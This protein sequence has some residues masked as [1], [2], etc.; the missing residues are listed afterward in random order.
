M[1]HDW[2]KYLL[3]SSLALT[4]TLEIVAIVTRQYTISDFILTHSTVKWRFV[5]CMWLIWH[6]VVEYW[7][8]YK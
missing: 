4:F 1:K 7:G 2:F 6:L 3:L 5:F 8:V